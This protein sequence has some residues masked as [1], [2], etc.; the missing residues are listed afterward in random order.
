MIRLLLLRFIV[1]SNPKNQNTILSQTFKKLNIMALII[2]I[3][4]VNLE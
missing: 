3:K 1:N 2:F 4:I